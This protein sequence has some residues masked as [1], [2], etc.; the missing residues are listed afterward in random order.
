MYGLVLF[1]LVAIGLVLVVYGIRKHHL[2]PGIL[3]ALLAGLTLFFFWFLDFWG[4]MLW[5]QSLGY[6]P[7][8][9]T[10]FWTKIGMFVAGGVLGLVVV[11]A[12]TWS[13]RQKS[14]WFRIIPAALGALFGAQWGVTHWETILRYLH[15]VSTDVTEPIFAKDTGFYLFRLPLYDALYAL[16]FW[17]C[18]VSLISAF[19]SMF[20]KVQITTQ[21][22]NVDL[23]EEPESV[24]QS[25]FPVYLNGAETSR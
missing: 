4:E 22:V 13:I 11:F 17:V 6:G 25:Y 12:L 2:L 14:K 8:F 9:W 23:A 18:A 24:P 20:L 5:F 15:S 21:N 10:V 1:I 16:L 3:G 19:I 7:R